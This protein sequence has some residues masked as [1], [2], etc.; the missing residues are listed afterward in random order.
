M[1]TP[2]PAITSTSNA[3]PPGNP[4]SAKPRAR[5]KLPMTP[6]PPTG[7]PTVTDPDADD[8]RPGTLGELLYARR[9]APGVAEQEWVELVRG[10]ADGRQDAL[11]ALYG[12]THRIAFTLIMRITGNR[13]T[14]EEVTLDVFHDVWRRAREYDAA[15]GS[16]LGW[17][18][19]QARS[20]AIDRLRYEGR[21]KRKAPNLADPA[22][23]AAA[24][25][26]GAALDRERAAARLR[27]AVARLQPGERHA[28]EA[29]FFGGLSYAEVAERD[30][31]PVGTVKTR[32]RSA[33]QKLRSDI[34]PGDERS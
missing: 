19:N 18:M 10:I 15:S 32:I 20:R 4:S 24:D 11:H 33:L 9:T 22:T 23:E 3:T 29:A 31:L 28:I 5:R 26:H 21:R 34:D 25:E 14:A 1:V 12:K 16:V 13:E 17:I 7:G 2:Q 27:Q 8:S 6:R 30:E